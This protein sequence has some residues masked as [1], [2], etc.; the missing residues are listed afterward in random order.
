MAEVAESYGGS[1]GT[2]LGTI[3]ADIEYIGINDPDEEYADDRYIAEDVV[4]NQMFVTMMIS[5]SEHDHYR[6]L[7]DNFANHYTMGTNNYPINT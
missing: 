6:L 4:C 7:K 5:G 3:K 2:E 1:Y